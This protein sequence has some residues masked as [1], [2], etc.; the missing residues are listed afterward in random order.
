MFKG[1]VSK[2]IDLHNSKSQNKKSIEDLLLPFHSL[3]NEA[4]SSTDSPQLLTI[5]HVWNTLQDELKYV[6]K[7][8]AGIALDFQTESTTTEA[9]ASTIAVDNVFK[10]NF[11]CFLFQN[12]SIF[13]LKIAPF[14]IQFECGI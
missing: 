4:L 14:P 2:R 13:F 8:L 11:F 6:L 3:L 1:S 5:Q 7:E 9:P 12:F 10:I